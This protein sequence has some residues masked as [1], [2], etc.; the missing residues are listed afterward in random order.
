[1]PMHR[2]DFLTL[3]GAAALDLASGTIS[4]TALEALGAT[5]KPDY[6]IRIA[7]VSVELTPTTLIKTV[8]YNAKA[9]SDNSDTRR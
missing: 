6:T 3:S 8:G 1:M 2:R 7:P 9:R 4:P 5:A